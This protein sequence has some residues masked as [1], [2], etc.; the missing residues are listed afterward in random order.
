[1]K[2]DERQ[3]NELRRIIVDIAKECGDIMK[4]ANN[5][6]IRTDTKSG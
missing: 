6:T 3:Q 2:D 4:S 5:N 1:M